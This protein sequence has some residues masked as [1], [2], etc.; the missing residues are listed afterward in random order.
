MRMR[1]LSIRCAETAPDDS[2]EQRLFRLAEHHYEAAENCTGPYLYQ[3]K[4]SEYGKARRAYKK[5]CKIRDSR[6]DTHNENATK[7]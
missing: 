5:A 3:A 2:E 1:I 6:E 4:K 7:S